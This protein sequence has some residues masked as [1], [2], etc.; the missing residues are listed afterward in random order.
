MRLLTRQRV[1]LL[2]VSQ[3]QS[4]TGG[5]AARQSE[6]VALKIERSPLGVVACKTLLSDF[7]EASG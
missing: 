5:M 7:T 4:K 2:R 1:N 6:I 3:E